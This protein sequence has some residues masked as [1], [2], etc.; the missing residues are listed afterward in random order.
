MVIEN[1]IFILYNEIFIHFSVNFEFHEEDEPFE[2]PGENL[3]SAYNAL[4]ATRNPTAEPPK[5]VPAEQSKD[6]TVSQSNKIL[7]YNKVTLISLKEAN[8]CL[9]AR[10]DERLEEFQPNFENIGNPYQYF[11]FAVI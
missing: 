3:L 4:E 10:E 7:I 5:D 8:T 11:I 2:F 6:A 9:E 1:I